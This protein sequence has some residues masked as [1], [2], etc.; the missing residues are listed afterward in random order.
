MDKDPIPVV[1]AA[2]YLC[3]GVLS[4]TNGKT[5]IPG[6]FAVGETACTGLHG[7]NRL[8]SNSL[9]ECVVFSHNAADW[10]Q[11]NIEELTLPSVPIPKWH[12]HKKANA[13]ELIVVSHT[14]DEIRRLMWNYVGI[15][16][17]RRRL[18]RAHNRLQNIKQEIA[19]YYEN[20]KTHP[21]VVE[22]RNI[23]L[24]ADLTVQCALSR[25]ESRGIHYNIDYPFSME[26]DEATESIINPENMVGYSI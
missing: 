12:L 2:H 20:F 10:I 6:L 25:H 13:D 7:A 9:L 11:K 18:E 14:W 16:R 23:A 21:D 1:P 5:D 17:S 8:A 4:D 19:D 24:V 26:E 15:M 3:G 22:L